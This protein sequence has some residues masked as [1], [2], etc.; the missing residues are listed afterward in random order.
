MRRA[1]WDRQVGQ[2]GEMGVLDGG[3]AGGGKMVVNQAAVREWVAKHGV[4]MGDV[5]E[6]DGWMCFC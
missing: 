2:W 3:G 6:E 1:G 4:G 5:L